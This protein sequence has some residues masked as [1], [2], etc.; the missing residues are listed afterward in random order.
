MPSAMENSIPFTVISL[1]LGISK[2]ASLAAQE[3]KI[4]FAVLPVAN[5][6]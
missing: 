6:Q 2:G 5:C 1:T 4:D 3:I